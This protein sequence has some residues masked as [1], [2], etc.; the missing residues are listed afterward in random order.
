MWLRLQD[1]SAKLEDEKQVI[2]KIM[3]EEAKVLNKKHLNF[4]FKAVKKKLK[5]F[6]Y[7]SLVLAVLSPKFYGLMLLDLS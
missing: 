3:K 7:L 2:E 1:S 5:I 4:C 6:R